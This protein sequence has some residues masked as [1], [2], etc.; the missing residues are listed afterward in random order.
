M[1]WRFTL[2][3]IEIDEPIGFAGI[4]FKG[5]RD[6]VWHGIFINAST[7]TLGF[8]GAAFDILKAAKE[9]D[10]VDATVIFSSE[11]RCEGET[12]YSPAISGKVNFRSYSESCGTE[13]II[14]MN[15]EDANCAMVF[16]NRFDQKVN[17]DSNIAFDQTTALTPYSGLGFNMPL[18]TQEIPISADAE[19]KDPNDIVNMTDVNFFFSERDLLIR[20][21]YQIVNDNSILTGQLNDPVNVFQD[22]G[23]TFPLSPQVLLEENPGCIDESFSYNIT[24]KGSVFMNVVS[25]VGSGAT[26]SIRTVVDYWDGN[27]SHVGPGNLTGDAIPLHND[28]V[29][30]I[31]DDE[32]VNFN[33]NYTGTVNLPVGYGL[34]AYIK[35]YYA[36]GTDTSLIADFDVTFDP[37]TSFF[38]SNVKACPPT[39]AQVYLINETLAHITEAIT[40]NCL[41]VQSDYYGRVDSQPIESA[42]DGCGGLRIVTPGLRIR[43]ATD[44]QFFASM[45]DLMDGL[46][47]IDNIGMGIEDDKI[48]IE[49][50]EYFYQD[51]KILDMVLVPESELTIEEGLIYSNILTGYD[52]WEIKSIKGIDEFNSTKEFRTDIK[53]VSNQ[54]NIRSKLITAGYIIEN[55][56]TQTLV[57]TGN[58]DNTYDNDIF[59]IC[60]DRD[61]YGYHVE[62]GV[63]D[64]AA[65]FFSPSTAYNWRVR[66]LYNLMRW[67]KSIGQQVLYFTAGTGNYLA[68]G[69]LNAADDCRLENKSLSESSDLHS[70][71]FDNT[72][73]ATPIY[74]PEIITF[75][76][77]LSIADYKL[78]KANPY[79]YINMQC[80]N[81]AFVKGFI[82]TFEYRPAEGKGKF[83]LL[84]KWQ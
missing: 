35:V 18:A 39:P 78:I 53:A 13:C 26:V 68:A 24:L 3:S 38:L 11:V 70:T 55:L 75:E 84:L 30:T 36:S 22:P 60:V 63:T 5:L 56:R 7:S 47:A 79:G 59:L 1:E 74:K 51:V 80:G 9:A 64:N 21:L 76:Y 32:T 45:K 28:L 34:Y 50:A 77:P 67:F 12:E 69:N 19:V 54:L 62:Q 48:R 49:P 23:N 66:P 72:I 14:R 33:V 41:T 46:R 16:K 83:E 43:Q 58:T 20:P 37:E 10:G 40:D 27:G 17:V 57:N 82:W 71:D 2:D 61:G 15:I 8:Y 65:D 52:K 31:L 25:T 6:P 42:Q 4:T 81:G 73:D 29:D 44:K